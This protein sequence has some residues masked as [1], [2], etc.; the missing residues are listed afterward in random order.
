M[1]PSSAIDPEPS[2]AHLT[3]FDVTTPVFVAATPIGKVWRVTR[4]DGSFAALKVYKD[5]DMK[6]ERAG[7][8]LQKAWAGQGAAQL[9]DVTQNAALL[10]WLDGPSLGDMVRDGQDAEATRA[11]GDVAV[12][13]HAS[14]PVLNASLPTLADEF[15]TL[16]NATPLITCPPDIRALISQ[17]QTITA[18]LLQSQT[19]IRPL[20]RDLHHDNIKGSQRGFLAFDAKGVIGERAYELANA[21]RN[22]VAA[23]ACYCDP[24]VIQKRLAHWSLTFDV[25]SK[26]LLSW[27][28]AHVGLS[29][30]W[31]CDGRFTDQ[32]LSKD[33][34]GCTFLAEA[35]SHLRMIPTP[36]Q[37]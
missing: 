7:F 26:R 12:K 5:G 34:A 19:D 11:L 36:A 17:A 16:L 4:A 21:F 25:P 30:A 32:I 1:S 24:I 10:E 35:L 23:E 8:D 37:P 3:R 31:Q 9:Y 2:A 33:A 20:H 18:N 27:A 6:D 13:L 14:S 28:V 29:L 22:P 15:Q